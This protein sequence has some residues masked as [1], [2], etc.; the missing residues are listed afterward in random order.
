MQL[1]ELF[2]RV[3]AIFNKVQSLTIFDQFI[4][5]IWSAISKQIITT[6]NTATLFT[7]KKDFTWLWW[8]SWL[9]EI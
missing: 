5:L 1:G 4:P 7:Y 6:T 9:L 8:T 2:V 3:H